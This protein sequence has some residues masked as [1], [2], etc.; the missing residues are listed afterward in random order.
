[1]TLVQASNYN[2]LQRGKRTEYII[3][4]NKVIYSMY[5]NQ[6]K[7]KPKRNFF[8]VLKTDLDITTSVVTEFKSIKCTPAQYGYCT[9]RLKHLEI[10]TEVDISVNDFVDTYSPLA[11][12]KYAKEVGY[13]TNSLYV[14][15]PDDCNLKTE[16][17]F[18]FS[19]I[20]M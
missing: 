19:S 6:P 13:F 20:S 11:N 5:G 17:D 9:N 4:G 3:L 2:L 1:M 12:F 18:S 8:P 14:H 7:I 10:P 15:K 16:M